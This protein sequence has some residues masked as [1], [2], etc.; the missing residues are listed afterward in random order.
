[1]EKINEYI[2]PYHWA[3]VGYFKAAYERPVKLILP[4]FTK[5]DTVLDVGCGDGKLTSLIAPN[6]KKVI[7]VDHQEYPLKFARLIFERLGLDNV[8][9]KVGDITKLSFPN[10]T[11][12]KVT[13]F[14]VIEHIPQDMAEQGI[15]ELLRVLKPGGRL[16]LTTPN[17]R[18][19]R[20]RIFGH[21]VID[22]HYYEY[23]PKELARYFAPYLDEINVKGYCLPI[24]IPKIEHI[25]NIL[26]FRYLFLYLIKAGYNYPNLSVGM[27]LSGTKKLD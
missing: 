11:F 23:T 21:V 9:F 6:V 22:K 27:L 26:P 3:W 19:L 14:D 2:F 24:P 8:T 17:R 10:N 12:D 15:K 20:G 5:S 4:E 25:A 7:G 18:E 1:M 16:Y 13:C